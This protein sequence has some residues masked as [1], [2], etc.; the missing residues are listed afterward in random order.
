MYNLTVYAS[1]KEN[2]FFPFSGIPTEAHKIE[3]SV[4]LETPGREDAFSL[5]SSPHPKDRGAY[6]IA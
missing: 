3:T 5:P 6:L 2:N 1:T 4:L